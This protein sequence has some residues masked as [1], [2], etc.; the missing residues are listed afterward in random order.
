MR[1]NAWLKPGAYIVE[2]RSCRWR[3]TI[4]RFLYCTLAYIVVSCPQ[5][6]RTGADPIHPLLPAVQRL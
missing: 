2:L 6:N 3:G 5:E 1:G 4:H